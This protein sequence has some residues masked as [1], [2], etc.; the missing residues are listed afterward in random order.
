MGVARDR[1]HKRRS[2]GGKQTPWRKK[3]KFELA[4]PP[5]LTKIGGR[6][7]HDV[8]V[9]G[10]ATKYRAL[11]LD[12]GSFA[13]GSEAVNRKTRILGVTYNASNNEYVRTN[14]LVKNS[15]VQ[16][17]ATPFKQW[18]EQH[19]GVF[20][21]KRKAAK[22]GD[23]AAAEE[24]KSKRSEKLQKERQTGRTIDA[25]LEEQ[26]TTGRLYASISSRPGQSGVAHGYI[27]EGQELAFY[28]RKMQKK[29]SKKDTK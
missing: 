8:R 13:W 15:I 14:T 29:K 22:E 23:A 21:G 16:V 11:R 12:N 20:L 2:T 18:Y 17:D 4:R 5:A 24:K 3:R 7:V 26:F 25:A 9:R 19:Y 6:R 10:G 1:V 28:V 27:L